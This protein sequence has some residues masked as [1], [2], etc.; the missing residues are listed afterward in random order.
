MIKVHNP[1]SL[2]KAYFYLQTEP[3][4]I[5]VCHDMH[6][7][8]SIRRRIC[9]FPVA[10]P[11]TAVKLDFF[12]RRFH[13][14]YAACQVLRFHGDNDKAAISPIRDWLHQK[15]KLTYANAS[16]SMKVFCY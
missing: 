7:L 13:I 2:Y 4:W 12:I 11:N 3:L 1:Q 16:E 6:W 8:R 15:N 10:E 5:L 9:L 14:F